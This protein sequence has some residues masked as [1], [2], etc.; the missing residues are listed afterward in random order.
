MPNNS[1]ARRDK[2]EKKNR[3]REP[4]PLAKQVPAEG[5]ESFLSRSSADSGFQDDDEK[6]TWDSAAGEAALDNSL[7]SLSRLASSSAE[8]KE[9]RKEE[10]ARKRKEALEKELDEESDITLSDDSSDRRDSGGSRKLSLSPTQ[11]LGSLATGPLTVS[12]PRQL[13][14]ME[15][16]SALSTP[17]Q[18]LEAKRKETSVDVPVDVEAVACVVTSGV[19]TIQL[20]NQG[21]PQARI[22]FYL[23]SPFLFQYVCSLQST[24]ER[25]T[26]ILQLS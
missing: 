12:R 1:S 16:P 14:S 18:V 7:S 5:V 17:T 13:G 9:T 15:R 4:P 6:V 19:N 24:C 22:L 20:D 10:R 3:R 11:F 21:H 26:A 23:P 2:S 8:P 25:F